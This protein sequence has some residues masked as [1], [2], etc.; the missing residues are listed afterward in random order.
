VESRTPLEYLIRKGK[1]KPVE[2][3]QSIRHFELLT[4]LMQE[5]DFIHYEI[6]N[7]CREGWYARHNTNYWNGRKYLG[8]GPSAHSY[9]GNTRQWNVSGIAAYVEA[10]L[11]GSG[12]DGEE[13]LTIAQHYNEY[14]MTSLRTI[15][16]CS[17]DEIS[18]RYGEN[19]ARYIRKLSA[20]YLHDEKLILEDGILRISGSG[21]L[22][23]DAIASDLFVTESL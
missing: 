4:E 11:K 2:E 13:T 10:I 21:L 6:S 16:G 19:Y 17:L 5:N 7:F 3:E 14:V 18:K 23:A 9:N 20:S 8:V 1:A 12:P 15:W 22:M